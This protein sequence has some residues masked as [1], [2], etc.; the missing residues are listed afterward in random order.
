MKTELFSDF[1]PKE[2]AMIIIL[3]DFLLESRSALPRGSAAPLLR[4]KLRLQTSNETKQSV[5]KLLLKRGTQCV[6]KALVDWL[7]FS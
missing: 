3:I 1:S 7:L 2:R 5:V 6:L 4:L